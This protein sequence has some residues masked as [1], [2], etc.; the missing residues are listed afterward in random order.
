[1]SYHTG[2]N[3]EPLKI[4]LF[5]SV[6]VFVKRTLAVQSTVLSSENP[7]D[8]DGG[9]GRMLPFYLERRRCCC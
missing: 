5:L 6:L 2:D 1:M 8:L 9:L 3:P 4:H 7:D